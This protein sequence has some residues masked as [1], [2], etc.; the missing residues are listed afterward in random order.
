MNWIY[1]LKNK[2]TQKFPLARQQNLL[3]HSYLIG[4]MRSVRNAMSNKFLF[5][6]FILFFLYT[7]LSLIMWLM[8]VFHHWERQ[9]FSQDFKLVN[10]WEWFVD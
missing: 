7:V 10:T 5:S 9:H 4:C 6:Y 2:F 1:F 3:A 8:K